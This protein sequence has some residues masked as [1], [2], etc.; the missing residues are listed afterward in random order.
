MTTRPILGPATFALGAASLFAFAACQQVLGLD[1]PTVSI[2]AISRICE[3]IPLTQQGPAFAGGDTSAC[4][5][6]LAEQPDELLLAVAENDCTDCANVTACY[7]LLTE[8]GDDG[9]ACARSSDCASWACCQGV[10]DVK[11]T[12]DN[13]KVVPVLDS[14]PP[15]PSCCDS[16]Q[17]CGEAFAKLNS[18]TGVTACAEAKAPLTALLDCLAKGADGSC[19]CL[20]TEVSHECIACLEQN[21]IDAGACESELQACAADPVRPVPVPQ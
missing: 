6:A 2:S 4:E 8:A 1:Q 14:T 19:D 13:G 18:E 15:E 16:C 5:S 9:D 11:L 7:A 12:L 20:A 21:A 17:S 10:L 3:C